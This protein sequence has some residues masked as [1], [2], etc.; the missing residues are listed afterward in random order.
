GVGV[1][2]GDA[3]PA[4][5]KLAYAGTLAGELDA[6]IEELER[7]KRALGDGAAQDA[8]TKQIVDLERRPR[9][10]TG[11][12]FQVVPAVAQA[13]EAFRRGRVAFEQKR[14]ADAA[15]LY[16]AGIEMAPHLPR[17]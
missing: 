1:L 16:R 13:K 9:G 3:D 4:L 17:N 11:S 8:V 10:F 7:H 6:A 2:R 15:G 14:W 5:E 12:V